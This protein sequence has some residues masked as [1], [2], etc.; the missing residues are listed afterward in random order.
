MVIRARRL[1]IT[2]R[3]HS[4][5]ADLWIGAEIGALVHDFRAPEGNTHGCIL[6]RSL[7]DP[8]TPFLVEGI[9]EVDLTDA[10]GSGSDSDGRGCSVTRARHVRSCSSRISPWISRSGGLRD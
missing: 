6:P 3:A 4:E 9:F 10:R 2:A 7:A 8:R 5:G 1:P